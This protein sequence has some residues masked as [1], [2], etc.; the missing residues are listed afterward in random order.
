MASPKRYTTTVSTTT[1]DRLAR[2]GAK[3]LSSI[4]PLAV[5]REVVELVKTISDA[6]RERE[7]IW[8]RREV[9]VTALN[10]EKELLLSYF[11]RRFSERENALSA[12][13]DLLHK[14]VDSGNSEVLQAALA[15]ILGVL[16]DS[17]LSDLESFRKAMLD[18][19]TDAN[20]S[21]IIF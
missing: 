18:P 14:A 9:L 8:A 7:A 19:N 15:G 3:V 1:G 5:I 4:D 11:D 20:S 6:D 17:P 16:K 10:N 21:E 13:Y 12:F 2:G